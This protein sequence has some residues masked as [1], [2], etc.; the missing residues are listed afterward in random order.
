VRISLPAKNASN[1]R[2]TLTLYIGKYPNR[3]S[4]INILIVSLAENH[5][6]FGNVDDET[7]R[8]HSSYHCRQRHTLSDKT[9]WTNICFFVNLQPM[10]SHACV[11]AT[12]SRFIEIYAIAS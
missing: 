8:R 12:L 4:T 5:V 11:T 7:S 1:H 3:I 10:R 9:I 2:I 6:I